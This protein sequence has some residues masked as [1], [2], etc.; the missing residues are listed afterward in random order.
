MEIGE[1]VSSHHFDSRALEI[2]SGVT[3]LRFVIVNLIFFT[4]KSGQN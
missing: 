3:V 1:T 4:N 2:Y